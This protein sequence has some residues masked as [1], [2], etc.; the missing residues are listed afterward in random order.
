M[1][2]RRRTRLHQTL[3]IFALTLAGPAMVSVG[4]PATGS[5]QNKTV[6]DGVYTQ[7]QAARGSASFASSCARC[8]SAEPNGGEEGRSLTGKGFW[9][10]YRESTVDHLLDFV[11]KNMPNGAGGSLSANTYT[12]LV[13]FI[14]SRNDLPAGSME[15]TKE[16]ANGVKIMA[17]DGPGELPSGTLVRVVGCIAKR[18]GGGWDIT[19]A[20]APERPNPAEDGNDVS[21]PLGTRSFR[22]MYVLT[23]LDSRVGQRV[24]VRGLLIGEGGK[25]GINLSQA[26]PLSDSCK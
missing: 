1:Q 19:S 7:Q 24:R 18:E 14:L 15:L 22:L 21:R 2:H 10:S 4:E 11:S 20:T 5:M 25:D 6:W 9:D 3:T 26:D 13:A 8:H 12:D 17:K 16:S 23:P